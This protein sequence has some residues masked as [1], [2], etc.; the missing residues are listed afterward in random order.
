MAKQ[1][2]DNLFEDVEFQEAPKFDDSLFEDTP[3]VSEVP[4]VGMTEALSRGA[5]QGASF[6]F[7][8]EAASSALKGC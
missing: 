7:S 4:E 8:E 1:F 2:D 6:G 3:V 5:L